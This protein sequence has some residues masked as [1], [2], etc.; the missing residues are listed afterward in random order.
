MA[1]PPKVNALLVC[2][3]TVRDR[4]SD[5][6][7]LVAV[8][9]HL[10]TESFPADHGPFAIYFNVSSLNGEYEF[11]FQIVAPDGVTVLVRGKLPHPIAC[12]DPLLSIDIGIG[13]R[14]I[15]LPAPGCYSI[16]LLYNGAIAE[17]ATLRVARR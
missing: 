3:G 7:T 17:T 13:I 12:R 15:R 9:D 8:Y 10:Q 14:E 11:G 6:T 2:E 5:R 16:R 1:S 4:I